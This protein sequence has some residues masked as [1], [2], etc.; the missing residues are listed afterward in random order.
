MDAQFQNNLSR[1]LGAVAETFGK[2]AMA[3]HDERMQTAKEQFAQM[4]EDKKQAAEDARSNASETQKAADRAAAA[5]LARQ[6]HQADRQQMGDQF[7]QQQ[8]RESSQF[9]ITRSQEAAR[10]A[11]EEAAAKRADK[12]ASGDKPASAG[13]K[14]TFA[15]NAYRDA[16]AAYTNAVKTAGSSSA[17]LDPRQAKAAK[18]DVAAKLKDLQDAKTQMNNI[19]KATGVP[20]SEA[21]PSTA[22]AAPSAP[23]IR[24]DAQGKAWT[25]GPDGKPVPYDP[26]S[27][28]GST[29]A[30]G[31]SGEDFSTPSG[32]NQTSVQPGA[33][34]STAGAYAQVQQPAVPPD[35]QN[36][37]PQIGAPDPNN[38]QL[39]A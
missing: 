10:I 23:K 11:I 15:Q 38:P 18:A 26:S 2:Y 31:G 12:A 27:A 17:M 19:A 7:Q 36:A 16:A 3:A 4:L 32:D 22:P 30:A 37:T 29:P 24:Y 5:E 9:A 33:N 28:S 1:G 21:T 14:L 35:P 25:L 20:I 39:A 8:A 34:A 13:E 6:Q